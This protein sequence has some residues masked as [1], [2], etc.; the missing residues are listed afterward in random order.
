M[1]FNGAKKA[2]PHLLNGIKRLFITYITNTNLL[3]LGAIIFIEF[4]TTRLYDNPGG[5]IKDSVSVGLATIS[6]KNSLN[7]YPTGH[8]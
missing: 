8:P 2:H 1:D 7:R 3:H 5:F 4:H 6:D